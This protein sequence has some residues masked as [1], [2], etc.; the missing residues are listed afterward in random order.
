MKK[1][2]LSIATL[3]FLIGCGNNAQ[4]AVNSA[5]SVEYYTQNLEEAKTK[6]KECEAKQESLAKEAQELSTGKTP[7][8]EFLECSNARLAVSNSASEDNNASN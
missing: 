5:K 3:A 4:D 2:I 8:V 1:T 7:S 6:A